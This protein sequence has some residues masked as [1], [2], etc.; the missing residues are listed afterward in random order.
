MPRA[1]APDRRTVIDWPV[2]DGYG[3]E[4]YDDDRAEA[5]RQQ[6][7]DSPEDLARAQRAALKARRDRAAR[8][9]T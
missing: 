4:P 9:Q 2:G 7:R 6:H 5:S 1:W 8:R 3:L